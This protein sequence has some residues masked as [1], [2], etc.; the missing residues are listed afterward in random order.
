[1]LRPSQTVAVAFAMLALAAGAT[2]PPDRIYVNARVWTGEPAQPEAQAFAVRGDRFVA[3]G[4]DA[5]VGGRAGPRTVIT[6]LGGLR[7]VPG[8]NDAHW[9]LPSRR[10]APVA[11]TRSMRSQRELPFCHSRAYGSS[12]LR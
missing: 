6:D 9:H 1:M 12:R 7:V 10:S 4:T 3:V 8:F 11:R 5:D 2:E